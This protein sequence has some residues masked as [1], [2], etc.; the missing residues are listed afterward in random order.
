M[1]EEVRK[2]LQKASSHLD[3]AK[4]MLEN[5]KLGSAV[6]R[7]YYAMFTVV[8]AALFPHGIF[9]KSHT[10]AH[11]KFRE[12]YLKNGLLPMELNRMLS[13]VFELRQEVDY[14]FEMLEDREVASEA[15]GYAERFCNVF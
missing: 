1:S 10:G 13:A 3:D 14:D 8:Q 12:L 7:A 9:T 2:Y 5:G 6:N 15:V 11:T 4:F